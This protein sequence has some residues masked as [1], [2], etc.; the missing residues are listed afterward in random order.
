MTVIVKEKEAINLKVEKT[1]KKLEEGGWV[2]AGGIKGKEENDIRILLKYL[3]LYVLLLVSCPIT[4]TLSS[5][6]S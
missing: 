2:G 5:T 1:W 6:S 4:G 3:D